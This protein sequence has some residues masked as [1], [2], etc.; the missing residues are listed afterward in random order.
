MNLFDRANGRIRIQVM[1]SDPSK[2]N[3][4]DPD[5]QNQLLPHRL[6][7]TEL[8]NYGIVYAGYCREQSVNVVFALNR[9]RLGRACLRKVPVSCI[10][11]LNYQGSDVS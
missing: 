10:G 6:K 5:W 7:N 2:Q 4:S 3:I 11:I 9:Y 1:N 8:R